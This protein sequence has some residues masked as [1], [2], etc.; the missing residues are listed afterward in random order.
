MA[1][2]QHKLFVARIASDS[3]I[4]WAS[5][6]VPRRKL[7]T[8]GCARS[9]CVSKSSCRRGSNG[10]R[11]D[12]SIGLTMSDSANSA[13]FMVPM[14]RFSLL[15]SSSNFTKRFKFS[16][17]TYSLVHM[18]PWAKVIA[19]V[20]H[21]HERVRSEFWCFLV[22][23]R[24]MSHFFSNGSRIFIHAKNKRNGRNHNRAR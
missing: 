10:A 1:S 8:N 20:V 21:Y 6:S 24:H 12:R 17:P 15:A 3:I 14:R 11:G 5:M 7:A 2:V 18:L 9:R 23:M 19:H 13:Y 22:L 4:C 16:E